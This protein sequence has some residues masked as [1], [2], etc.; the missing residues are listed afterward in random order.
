[1]KNNLSIRLL[2][3]DFNAHEAKEIL[4]NLLTDKIRFHEKRSFSL[5]ERTGVH[6]EV[7]ENRIKSLKEEVINLIA[8]FDELENSDNTVQLDSTISLKIHEQI[9]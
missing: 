4:I 2:D 6:D 9:V 7:S 3:G 5:M 8:F 1:M